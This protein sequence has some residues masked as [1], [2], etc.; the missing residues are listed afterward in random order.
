MSSSANIT[1]LL[2]QLINGTTEQKPPSTSVRNLNNVSFTTSYYKSISKEENNR[3]APQ[4]NATK[5]AIV[6][7]H[8]DGSPTARTEAAGADTNWLATM[9]DLLPR[10][11]LSER[12]TNA[13]ATTGIT[14]Y[15]RYFIWI[16][17]D[18]IDNDSEIPTIIESEIINLKRFPVCSIKDAS[19]MTPLSEGALIRIDFENRLTSSD[20]YIISIMNNSEEFGRTIITELGGIASAANG[21]SPCNEQGIAVRHP[22]GDALGTNAD[23]FVS[24][25]LIYINGDAI[26][27]YV[28]NMTSADLVVFY[29]G[30]EAD[31]DAKGRQ[32]TIL[33]AL[34]PHMDSLKNSNKL[35]LIPS[36][37]DKNYSSVENTIKGLQDT[38]EIVVSSKKL[39][40]WS[41]GSLGGKTALEQDTFAQVEI[42]DPSPESNTIPSSIQTAG[43]KISMTYNRSNWGIPAYYVDNIDDYVAFMEADGVA[44]T[45]TTSTHETIMKEAIGRLVV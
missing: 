25:E 40:F 7:Q 18:N 35:F 1:G 31:K 21:F 17:P 20:A 12:S 30:I 26:Y 38:K 10:F 2:A 39:G 42:A 32:N 41:G 27:P 6:L 43:D 29:H 13:I 11:G 23:D 5:K 45:E 24:D 44:V 36:G 19:M 9:I 22:S 14:N 28:E 16:L 3:T 33:A 34:I 15:P 4:I 8:V 37:H